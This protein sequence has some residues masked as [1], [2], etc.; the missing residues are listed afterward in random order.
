MRSFF[1]FCLMTSLASI[2]ASERPTVT[3]QKGQIVG[4]EEKSFSGR[5]YFAFKRIPY[6]EPPLKELRFK[7]TNL[8]NV[9]LPLCH[10]R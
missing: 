7:V 1:V 10:S 9:I 4:L 8:V 3:S 6:A 2:W 5:N